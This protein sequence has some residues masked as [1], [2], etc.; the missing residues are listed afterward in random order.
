MYCIL[1]CAPIKDKVTLSPIGS[2]ASL[3][4]Q[5]DPIRAELRKMSDT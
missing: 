1:P 5:M 2:A 3:A 4:Q